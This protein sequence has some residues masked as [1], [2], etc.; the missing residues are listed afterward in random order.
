[1]NH[2]V[3]KALA[4]TTGTPALEQKQQNIE[5][6]F[7]ALEQLNNDIDKK[8]LD[9]KQVIPPITSSNIIEKTIPTVPLNPQIDFVFSFT[10]K[11]TEL[12]FG[13]VH[14]GTYRYNTVSQTFR[15]SYGRV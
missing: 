5:E 6:R 15:K 3:S 8:L 4:G 11:F 12:T 2:N 13:I 10:V 9:E 1:V 7:I 14:Q